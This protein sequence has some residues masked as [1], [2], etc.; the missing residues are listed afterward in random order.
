VFAKVEDASELEPT[1]KVAFAK[2]EDASE[3]GPTSHSLHLWLSIE[4]N[5][6]FR[7]FLRNGRCFTKPDLFDLSNLRFFFKWEIRRVAVNPNF[8]QIFRSIGQL[9]VASS[10]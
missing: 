3:P 8:A 5:N 4:K 10:D 1:N 2:A 7:E 6:T 9:T